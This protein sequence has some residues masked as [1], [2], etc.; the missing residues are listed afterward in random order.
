VTLQKSAQWL[1]RGRD[2]QYGGRAVDAMLCFRRALREAPEN[3]DARF[4]L[5][6]VLW[7]LG[8]LPDAIA[9]WKDAAQRAP[10]L[11]PS[12][13]ALA[14]ALLGTGEPAAASEAAARV[15]ALE[16]D[17]PQAGTIIAIGRLWKGDSTAMVSICDAI[18]R[19]WEVL[20]STAI[21]G[22]LALAIDREPERETN[23]TII[24]TVLA[25]VS[26]GTRVAAMPASLFALALERL[27]KRPDVADDSRRI[28]VD[29]ALG[30]P[31]AVRD[32]DAVR[33]VAFAIA[34]FAPRESAELAQYYAAMCLHVERG[35]A[36]I[37]WPRRTAGKRLRVVV[38]SGEGDVAS[39]AQASIGAL[40]T[41][42]FDVTIIAPAAENA[43][44][45]GCRDA[46]VLVDLAGL[47]SPVGVLL[48]ARPARSRMT[49][50]SLR[51]HNR[52]PL[53]D[54]IADDADDLLAALATAQASL[55]DRDDGLDAAATA[56]LWTQAVDAHR[57]GDRVAACSHYRRFLETQPDFAPARYLLGVALREDGDIDAARQQFAAAL[58]AAPGYVAPRVDAI[59]A[60]IDVGDSTMAKILAAGV[61]IDGAPASLLRAQGSARLAVHDGAGAVVCF[62]RALAHEPID[63]E[64]HYN[65]GVALQMERR[66]GDAARA[67]QRALACDP[68]LV[69]ADFNL[70]TIFAEQGNRDAAIAAFGA[71][72]TRDPHHVAAYKNRGEQLFAAGRIDDWLANFRQFEANCP[73]ALP[74]AVQALEAC[75]YSGDFD[76]VERY[77]A[78]LRNERIKSHDVRELVSSLEELLYLLLY[79]DVEPELLQRF[80]ET[81][82]H[83][84]RTVYGIPLPRVGE[85]RPGKIRVGYLSADLRNHV[86]GKMIFQAIRHHD[87][88]RF[89]IAFYSTSTQ[90]DE[91]TERFEAAGDRFEV[92]AM[93]GEREAAE[94]IAGADLDLLVDLSTHTKGARPG[95][96]ALKPARVQITHVASAGT[97]GLSS[98]DFKLT[99]RY[100]DVDENQRYQVETLL[101]M[102]GCVYPYRHVEV[103][104]LAPLRR[105]AFGIAQDAVVIGTFV[106]GLKL[107][108]RCLALWRQVLERIPRARLAFSP[109]N[110]A[111]APLYARLAGAAGIDAHRI[112]FIPQA[113]TDSANQA[114]YTLV[115]FVLDPMPYGGVNGTLEALDMGVPVVTLVGKRH[116]ER[117]S[118]SILSN[119]GVTKTIAHSGSEYVQIATRLADDRTFM[120]EVRAAIRTGLSRSA[121][122]DMKAHT[123]NLEAAYLEALRRRAPD[124]LAVA[125][126]TLSER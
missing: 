88:N 41:E 34:G 121:L 71:V 68:N 63:G 2:H 21:G 61:P 42:R 116:A 104:N 110:A 120:A 107:S 36:P 117:T 78:G 35:G 59:R 72:L 50:A 29:A 102:A 124:A 58:G 81:Y 89:E 93:L 65:H 28:W 8:R 123:R 101:P 91:W 52:A 69:A 94:R 47:A 10:Q 114:R 6:E 112:V 75:Q 84:A 86:M 98:V 20:L 119:L 24:D 99:D 17:N 1:A 31:W 113:A 43:R 11:K 3:S 111:L 48:A 5:G 37:L 39:S 51:T 57:G 83:A 118:Y 82:D 44:A 74:L 62:E 7:Q 77:L 45:I 90:R 106:S 27:A 67:Y 23:A 96:V 12:H 70:G 56:T 14:E 115:D 103:A 38:L 19:H 105:E 30:R 87:R 9:V 109:V 95:I 80:A 16:P 26:D 32:H 55:V 40:P 60:A 18:A 92:V 73:D 122:T 4:H 85:R 33:R 53:V 46:D 13:Q 15:I 25:A 97:L 64:T 22:S 108:R 49:I 54:S 125:E 100:A 126:A 76:G 66:F 79:F